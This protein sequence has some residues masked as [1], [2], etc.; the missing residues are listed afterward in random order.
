VLR[1]GT[2]QPILAHGTTAMHGMLAINGAS[3]YDDWGAS[4]AAW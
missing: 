4:V 1:E 2:T 3:M